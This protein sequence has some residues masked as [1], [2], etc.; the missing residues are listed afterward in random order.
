V[1]KRDD[2]QRQQQT[3]PGPAID[4]PEVRRRVEA[5]ETVTHYGDVLRTVADV[6]AVAAVDE[7]P[8]AKRSRRDD[9][10]RQLAALD[11]ELADAP[12]RPAVGPR[13]PD[14][15]KSAAPATPGPDTQPTTPTQP[16]PAKAQPAAAPTHG[17]RK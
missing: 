10:Q 7:S 15:G 1:A 17:G 14:A 16:P 9:L 8:A 3:D 2:Q 12:G 6:D 4:W 11:Y 13:V 5:G